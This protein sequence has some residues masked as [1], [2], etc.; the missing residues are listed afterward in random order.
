MILDY[1]AKQKMIRALCS[2]TGLTLTLGK[3]DAAYTDGKRIVVP[4]PSPDFTEDQ[5][6]MWQYMVLHEAGHNDPE[7]RKCLDLSRE[8]G[9]DMSSFFGHVLNLLEDHR[10][11]WH[12]LR[13][14][15]SS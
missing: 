8:R 9:L 13:G 14:E 4:K 2:N 3:T 7:M 12:G 5:Y 15:V 10:Q 11:E 1:H 6:I